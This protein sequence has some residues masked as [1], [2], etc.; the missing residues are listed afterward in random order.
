[1]N[2]SIRAKIL[3][4]SIFLLASLAVMAGMGIFELRSA[5]ERTEQLTMMTDATGRLAAQV[6]GQQAKLT[7][8][9]RDL[10]LLKDKDKAKAA[11]EFDSVMR[12]RDELR[13]QLRDLRNP[14]IATKLEEMETAIKEYDELAK[15]VRTL[16]LKASNERATAILTS[17]GAGDKAT[18]D[19]FTT[20]HAL[21][22]ELARRA[23]ASGLRIE[24]WQ[25]LAQI[26]Q[27]ADDEKEMILDD[28]PEAMQVEARHIEER[29][30]VL[31]K[32][33][34]ALDRGVTTSE[35]KRLLATV[36]TLYAAFETS[37]GKARELALENA[38]V[39]AVRL[40]TGKSIEAV[41]KVGKA[42]DE[43][44]DIEN[45]EAKAGQLAG[46][47]AYATARVLMVIAFV[48]ALALGI[49]VSIVV[50]RYIAGAMA[51]A[52]S[53]VRAVASGDLTHTATVTNQ[54][55]IGRMLHT[56][57]DMVENLRRVARDVAASATSVATGSEQMSATAGQVAEGAGQQGAATEETTAAMEEM[58]A[59]VQQ[60]ADNAQQ[61]DRLASKASSDAQESGQAVAETVSAMKNIAEKIGIIEEIARKT[62]LLALN[63]AVEAARAGEHGKGFAVVASEV[64]KL[65]ERSA[66]AAAEISAQ[67]RQGV[68]LAESAGT[69]L[70]RLVPD[71]RKTAELVQEVSAA[72]REQSTGIEQTNKA[73]Q[74]LDRVT[75]QNASA[76]EQMAAT[77]AELSNQAQQ[78]QTAVAFFQ[79]ETTRGATPAV[80]LPRAVSTRIPRIATPTK[81]VKPMRRPAKLASGP[82]PTMGR[83]GHAA[84]RGIELDLGSPSSDDDE[85][86]ERH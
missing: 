7:R 59:S 73:L 39:A 61:T 28:D 78:L 11:A 64:R 38:D 44:V 77:A 30:E 65:A 16:A 21:D 31:R 68:M 33:F 69:M 46:A 49:G 56:L 55:E 50:S 51:N 42:S 47:S 4:L 66:T 19:M 58:A 81:P 37:H 75:Q 18:E 9:E 52:S 86:F 84:A 54:D 60:N 13:Q 6:R 14:A 27:T 36:H 63:A 29:K 5:N 82:T 3:G 22:A 79:L 20:L 41:L 53:L 35:E 43:I 45:A 17:G 23:D 24:V 2:L 34:A 70:S 25:A 85:M 83:N 62:D 72:S 48:L 74:D 26:A 10:V 71:I 80:R 15:Q 40:V 8:I 57:N 76:A 32:N 12:T 1:M 67:S